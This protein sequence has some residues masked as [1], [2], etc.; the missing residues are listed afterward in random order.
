[1]AVTSAPPE[2][3]PGFGQNVVTFYHQSVAEL[4]KVTWPDAA[5]I[6][7]ATIAIIVFVLLLGLVIWVLDLAGETVAGPEGDPPVR[8][9]PDA[10]DVDED[11]I[12]MAEPD[13]APILGLGG[14][15]DHQQ[16]RAHDRCS[17]T[18][19]RLPPLVTPAK[20]GVPAGERRRSLHPLGSQPSLGRRLPI[21]AEPSPRAGS[22]PG[23]DRIRPPSVIPAKAG[24][25]VHSRAKPHSTVFMDPGSSPG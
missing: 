20:A 12:V 2:P 23:A 1:M 25:H 7:Q 14:A 17:R 5:Q 4:K 10:V 11:D 6:R 19:L 8:L 22:G 24:I 3:K 21:A 16:D 13:G 15:G 18:H 9:S